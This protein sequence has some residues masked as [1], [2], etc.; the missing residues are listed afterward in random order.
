MGITTNFT[1]TKSLFL[2]NIS[3]NC[4]TNILFT[5]KIRLFV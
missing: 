2:D 3:N 5:L 4:W 1:Q